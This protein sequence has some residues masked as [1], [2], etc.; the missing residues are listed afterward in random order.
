MFSALAIALSKRLFHVKRAS[1]ARKFK[2][3]KGRLDL[4]AADQLRQKIELLRA[5]PQHAGDRLGFIVLQRAR[6]FLLGHDFSLSQPRL[7]FLSA[8]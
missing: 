7:A 1:L 3:G 4:L 5:D 2:I 6:R 8:A